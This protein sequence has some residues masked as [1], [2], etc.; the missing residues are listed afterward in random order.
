V[1]ELR[2]LALVGLIITAIV[3][4][5]AATGIAM[6]AQRIQ[7]AWHSTTPVERRVGS[8]QAGWRLRF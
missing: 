7:R 8:G 2:I 1:I 3:S 6:L 4:W 5:L